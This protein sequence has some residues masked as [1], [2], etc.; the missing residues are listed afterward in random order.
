MHLNRG[1]DSK[2]FAFGC[3]GSGAVQFRAIGQASV[4]FGNYDKLL[5]VGNVTAPLELAL[6]QDD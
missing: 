3:P 5:T 4:Q 1:I 6:F 2:D